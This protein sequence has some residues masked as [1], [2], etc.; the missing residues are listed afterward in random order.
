MSYEE[1]YNNSTDGSSLGSS[2]SSPVKSPQHFTHVP[3]QFN[4]FGNQ[5]KVG[6]GVIVDTSG[7]R[8][9]E[10]PEG[11]GANNPEFVKGSFELTAGDHDEQKTQ[12][13]YEVN[14]EK[15]NI[16][17]SQMIRER[18]ANRL[19][20]SEATRQQ[21]QT[22]QTHFMK[23]I[24]YGP[25]DVEMFRGDNWIASPPY[26]NREREREREIERKRERE[27]GID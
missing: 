23:S 26:G 17:R 4:T 25:S 24:S 7:S 9:T 3:P 1:L 8:L 21:I 22:R 19:T 11:W 18:K 10:I 2:S 6:Q 15:K 20:E 13:K 5:N 14:T 16:C 27:R 12:V